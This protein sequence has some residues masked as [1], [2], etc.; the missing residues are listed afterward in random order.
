M[1][2]N[3]AFAHPA[4]HHAMTGISPLQLADRLITLAA[5]ADRA[6]HAEIATDLLQIMYSVLDRPH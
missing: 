1:N 4:V 3:F 2:A 6:G 5:D